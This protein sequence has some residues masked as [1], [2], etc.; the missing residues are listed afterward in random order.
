MKYYYLLYILFS[1]LRGIHTY[2]F[3]MRIIHSPIF[4]FLP[5]MKLH[6]IIVMENKDAMEHNEKGVYTI[7]FTPIHQS[8]LKTQLRLLLSYNV[9]AEIRI[10]RLDGLLFNDTDKIL[11]KW[12]S[13][14]E[15]NE[16]QSDKLSTAI[17]NRIYNFELKTFIALV[18][19]WDKLMNM[20]THNC[21]HFS[22]HAERIYASE[23]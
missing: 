14:N 8:H 11:S 2:N 17:Y 12:N 10:R 18:K 19:K 1:F 16:Y 4:N 23:P 5:D 15:N 22:S 3:Q 9:P 6:H 7:D 13:I 21:Q 20:Y